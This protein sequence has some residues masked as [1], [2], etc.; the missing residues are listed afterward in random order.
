M[1]RANFVDRVVRSSLG[2]GATVDLSSLEAFADSPS[3]L[4][5]AVA[6]MLLHELLRPQELQSIMAAVSASSNPRTRVRNAVY[7][8]ATSSRYQV[9]H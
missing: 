9:Q 8:V 5:S 2:T 7:L 1:A 6:R 4:V 3:N